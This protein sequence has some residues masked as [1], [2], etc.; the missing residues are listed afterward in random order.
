LILGSNYEDSVKPGR[1]FDNRHDLVDL[2][3]P[4]G[5]VNGAMRDARYTMR[6][7]GFGTGDGRWG[8]GEGGW[9]MPDNR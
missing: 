1:N 8:M 7:S 4:H 9:Q 2:L 6:D 5:D 3:S